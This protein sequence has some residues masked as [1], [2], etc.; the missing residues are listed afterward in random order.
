MRLAF[1]E[2]ANADLDREECKQLLVKMGVHCP[3]RVNNRFLSKK[4][5]AYLTK[6]GAAPEGGAAPL[7][8]PLLLE[9]RG[10]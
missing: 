8:P 7:N 9:K 1:N 10:V 4:H 3:Q 2:R 5:M 6:K